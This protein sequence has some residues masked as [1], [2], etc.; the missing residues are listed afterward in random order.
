MPLKV[1]ALLVSKLETS[2]LNE[3]SRNINEKSVTCPTS[4]GK[5]CENARADANAHDI[6]WTFLVSQELQAKVEEDEVGI[7]RESV[8]LLFMNAP[9][10]L[11]K[12][13]GIPEGKVHVGYFGRV[14]LQRMIELCCAVEY[15]VQRS[16]LAHVPWQ[17]L[18]E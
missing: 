11:I 14:P 6:C 15:I 12:G 3:V 10:I 7:S 8:K 9:Q 2:P 4:H 1:M 16:H 17:R 5:S 13:S 18:I